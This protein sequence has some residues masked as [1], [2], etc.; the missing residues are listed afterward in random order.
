LEFAL[1]RGKIIQ[2]E[3][4]FI[5]FSQLAHKIYL[6]EGG[7]GMTILIADDDAAL[8]RLLR[9]ILKKQG[10]EVLEAASGRE[11]IDSFFGREPPDLVILDVMMPVYDGWEVLE[12]IRARSEVPVVMLTALGDERHEVKGLTHGADDYI[13]K[14]FSYEVFVA[15]VN[16]LLRRPLREQS[17]VL[18][19]GKLRVDQALHKAFLG[20]S[21]LALNN[22]EYRLLCFFLKNERIVL[23]RD[24]LL[25]NVWGFDFEGDERTVDAHVKMLRAKLGAAGEQ[26]R[27]V[28]GSG[29]VF[30]GKE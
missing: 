29:Y 30:E 16:A 12:E 6:P 14:P 21:E 24:K 7:V 26:I 5:C 15:R 2:I 11:A 4:Y 28:R 25:E 1:N 19:A 3:D 17:A 10:Y 18:R 8:R 13:A 20:E 27:T 9:D 23:T 22:K